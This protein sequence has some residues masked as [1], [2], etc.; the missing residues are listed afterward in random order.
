MITI[1]NKMLNELNDKLNAY[2][3][4]IAACNVYIHTARMLNNQATVLDRNTYQE[5]FINIL[6]DIEIVTPPTDAFIPVDDPS[7]DMF[8]KNYPK[9]ENES[10]E[11]YVERVK[12]IWENEKD[13]YIEKYGKRLFA[14]NQL[15]PEYIAIREKL[16]LHA[17]E[18]I[19]E[20]TSALLILIKHDEQKLNEFYDDLFIYYNL[21]KYLDQIDIIRM[22]SFSTFSELIEWIV[23]NVTLDDW[24]NYL[25]SNK[26]DVDKYAST[27]EDIIFNPDMAAAA[28]YYKIYYV[29]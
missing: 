25:K 15:T 14:V 28:K 13:A 19:F 23:G 29:E 16:P 26:V 4:N 17:I 9:N 11:E 2:K 27:C 6:S 10:Q 24:K 7:F 5:I 12:P 1:P 8:K 20:P 21:F 18:T 3:V 22:D